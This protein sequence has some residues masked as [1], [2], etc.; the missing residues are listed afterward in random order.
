AALPRQGQWSAEDYLWL[1]D[2]TNRLAEFT[3]GRI[4][5][6]PM[7]TDM[8][9]SISRH[10]FVAFFA[11]LGPR[12]GLVQYAP[13]RV[14][15]SPGAFREPDLVVLRDARDPRRQD[16]YW[17]GA[18]L[19]VEIVSPDNPDRDRVEKR[20]DY[21]AAGIP[22]Y[23]IIEPRGETITVLRLDGAA[24]AEHGVFGR[25]AR[26]TAATLAGFAVAVDAVFAAD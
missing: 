15:I 13:L 8:H 11:F 10:L 5:V 26:A 9:Q 19:V 12:G 18:D 25:G 20:R 3:A 7:P 23:W 14:R 1:T 16:R 21:A 24:Y 6:L 2:H 4:E 17:T 22:E